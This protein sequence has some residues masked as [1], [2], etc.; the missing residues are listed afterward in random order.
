[1]DYLKLVLRFIHILSGVFWVG[2]A[3]FLGFFVTPALPS[4]GEG[5]PKLMA[6]LVTKAKITQRIVI[7]ATLTV[8]AGGWLYWLDSSGNLFSGWA[9]SAAGIGFGIGAL[10]A[11]VG[12][13]FGIMIGVNTEGLV[14]VGSQV[15]GKPT[16]EQMSKI[17]MHQSRLK[18]VAP[19]STISQILALICMATARYW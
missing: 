1:M 10:F 19:I 18:F 4:L 5:G 15:Q 16:D 8:L 9:T 7:A 11:L 14:R 3:V 17:Q 6:Y 12:W 13:V 2:S